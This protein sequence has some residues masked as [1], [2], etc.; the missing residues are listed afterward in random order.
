MNTVQHLRSLVGDGTTEWV[1]GPIQ[2]SVLSEAADLIEMLGEQNET[3]SKE[4]E[5]WHKI[6]DGIDLSEH[7]IEVTFRP[8][9]K[10][11]T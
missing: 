2:A 3:M 5:R 6:T 8:K 10:A 4:L 7:L 11:R 9:D 1:T